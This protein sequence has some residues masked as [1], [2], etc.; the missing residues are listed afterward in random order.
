LASPLP[1][2]F[3]DCGSLHNFADGF[4]V[5]VVTADGTRLRTDADASSSAR[6][7]VAE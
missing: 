7:H 6:G 3:S 5:D 4:R 2:A 1:L